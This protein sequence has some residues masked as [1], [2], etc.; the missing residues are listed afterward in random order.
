MSTPKKIVA[1]FI[2]ICG[3]LFVG[4]LIHVVCTAT[5][6][7]MQEMQK[8]LPQ[9]RYENGYRIKT[10]GG[11]DFISTDDGHGGERLTPMN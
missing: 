4:F 5:P 2:I 11:R 3:A 6:E 7:Q 10:I 1:A 8:V 9:T